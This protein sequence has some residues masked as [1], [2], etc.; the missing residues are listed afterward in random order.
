[1]EVV[2]NIIEERIEMKKK[3][4]SEGGIV[5]RK[6]IGLCVQTSMICVA[7][8]CHFERLLQLL[9]RPLERLMSLVSELMSFSFLN[10]F[11]HISLNET[12]IVDH[13]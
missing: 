4:E 2:A 1:M 13:N 9:R 3:F 12:H 10:F 5:K 6:M 11:I 7:L 8:Y